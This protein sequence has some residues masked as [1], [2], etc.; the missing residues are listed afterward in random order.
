MYSCDHFVF[1]EYLLGNIHRD[2]ITALMYSER[3][4]AFGRA[5]RDALPGRCRECEWLF[6]CGGGCPKD[7]LWRNKNYLC[8]GYRMFFECIKNKKMEGFS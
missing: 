4:R 2:S 6:A 5:K 7:R 3:Q 8:E 1:P